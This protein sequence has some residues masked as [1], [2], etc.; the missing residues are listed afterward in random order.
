MDRDL[1]DDARRTAHRD[2]VRS[3]R[4]DRNAPRRSPSPTTRSFMTARRRSPRV[5][6]ACSDGAGPI[7]GPRDNAS[8]AVG[9]SVGA[10][11]T[12]RPSRGPAG[13]LDG[14]GIAAGAR[15]D[16]RS[17]TDAGRTGPAWVTDG[18]RRSATPHLVPER[19]S[20]ADDK[21]PQQVG[22]RREGLPVRHARHRTA[23]MLTGSALRG[24]RTR[25]LRYDQE[26][27][28]DAMR[29]LR[30]TARLCTWRP[31]PCS[32]QMHAACHPHRM[33]PAHR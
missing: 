13:P 20:Q 1:H 28:V 15:A 12:A 29:P 3:D 14:G 7:S 22:R 11:G 17:S 16:P 30:S 25:P 24:R 31:R 27:K 26:S 32:L 4:D 9:A 8:P 10:S 2:A 5:R 21:T 23:R 33:S 18:T 19:P 6:I